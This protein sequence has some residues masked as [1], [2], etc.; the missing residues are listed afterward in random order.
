[1]RGSTVFSFVNDSQLELEYGF[2]QPY[3][4]TTR[5]QMDSKHM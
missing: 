4:I 5:F 1:M 2:V 3:Q